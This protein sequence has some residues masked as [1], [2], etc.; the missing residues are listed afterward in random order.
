[1]SFTSISF[2][3]FLGI[4]IVL[5]YALPKKIQWIVLLAASYVFYFFAG[6]KYFAFILFTTITTYLVTTYMDR[7]NK[8][9]DAYM[10]EHKAE[11]SREEKKAYKQKVKKK[12]RLWFVITIAVNFGILFFCKLLL[13]EP[14]NTWAA[15]TPGISFLSIGLPMGMSFYMFQSMGYVIDVYREKAEA[16]RN[17][18][19]VA[20]FTAFFP[21]LV[22]GPISKFEQLKESL[23]SEHRFDRQAVAFGM[24]RMMWGFF[25]KMVIADRMAIAIGGLRAT[26]QTGVAFFVMTIFYSIQLYADFSGGIDIAIGIGE[27]LGIKMPENFIRPYFSMNIA[28]YWRRWHITLNEWMK[29]YIFYPINVSGPMLKLSLKARAKIGRLGMRLPVYIGALL[30]WLGTGVW[31]GFNWKFIVWG[32]INCIVIVASEELNP[33]YDKFHNKTHLRDHKGYAVFQI[34]RTFLMM[35]LIRS[36]DLFENVG[37][38][39]KNI[40]SLCWNF[41]FHILTDGT[42]GKIGITTADYLIVLCGVIIMFIVSLIQEKTGKS[43]RENMLSIPR[44][45]RYIILGA[46]LIIIIVFG[47]YG[48]GFESGNFIYGKI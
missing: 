46:F 21:Q 35:N 10:A 1:M 44:V 17:P 39:F 18:F 14:F 13:I 7:N 29:T 41:N 19:K 34:I 12:N 47:Y 30:T 23:F 43:V 8:A 48:I 40:G 5:Y 4:L 9:K 15:G 37:L 31:H 26:E 16:L 2:L 22:Q 42:L 27:T 20:L 24:Q 11:M 36:T 45:V 33:L 28:D 25:K 6:V 38:Y 3:L 32:L